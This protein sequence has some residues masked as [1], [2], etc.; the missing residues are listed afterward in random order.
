MTRCIF[1]PRET[2][3][4]FKYL[5]W[6]TCLKRPYDENYLYIGVLPAVGSGRHSG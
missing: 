4:E 6:F 1:L 2:K 3:N 5:V